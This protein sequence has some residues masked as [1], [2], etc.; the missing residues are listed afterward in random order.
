[1]SY[2]KQRGN[3]RNPKHIYYVSLLNS[4]EWQGVHGLRANTLRAHHFCQ[5]CE[6]AGIVRAAVDVHHLKPV[7]DVGR[8]YQPGEELPEDVKAAMR[9]RCFDPKNVI[10]LCV[11]CHIDIHRQMR[12]HYGQTARQM[13]KDDSQQAQDLNAWVNR[14]SNGKSEARTFKKGVRKT[15]YGWVTKDELKFKRAEEF[16]EWK[17]KCIE[18][19]NVNK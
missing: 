6:K 13:P 12:S 8:Y 7:E 9:E 11:P 14:V 2:T 17:Q 3:N 1:M 4:Q 16:E 19:S 18:M 10:A 15:R 5:L